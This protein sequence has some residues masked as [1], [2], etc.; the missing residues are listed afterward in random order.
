VSRLLEKVDGNE[1]ARHLRSKG[2]VRLGGFDLREED[3][4]ISERQ[5]SGYAHASLDEIHVYISLT[6]DKRLKIEGLAREVIRRVQHMRKEMGL[7]FEDAIDVEFRGHNDIETAIASHQ[8]HISHEIHA[9]SV[10][11][12]ENLEGG[13]K[14]TVNKMLL[15]LAVRKV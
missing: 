8:A 7:Q 4:I 6:V 5:K 14:W 3:V 11:K 2:K 9:R 13:T 10:V 15:E 1:L 12:N